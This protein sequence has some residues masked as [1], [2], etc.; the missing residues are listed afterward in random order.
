MTPGELAAIKARDAAIPCVEFV[1]ELADRRNLLEHIATLEACLRGV[2]SCSTC[3]ACR[4]AAERTLA[5]DHF[6]RVD[7]SAT[8]APAS[9]AHRCSLELT[10]A[11]ICDLYELY[12]CD[13]DLE[14]SWVVGYCDTVT[15]VDT[16][17]YEPPGLYAH[18]SEY[19]EEGY[20]GPLGVTP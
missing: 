5:G 10:G 17:K 3:D 11:Q 9:P 4:G 20:I 13:E 19:P 14:T 6:G 16:G 8:A 1:S 12:R 7:G 15:D 2:S 18:L